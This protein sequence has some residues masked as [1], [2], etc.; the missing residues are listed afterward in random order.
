MADFWAEDV[1]NDDGGRVQI[2]WA[3][4]VADDC[5]FVTVYMMPV[6]D[7]ENVPTNVDDMTEVAIVPDCE[8]N[9]TIIDSIGENSLVDG[10]AY[11]IGAVA[12]D[13]WLNGDTGDVTV[14]EV[15]PFVNNLNG[16]SEPERISEL[17]AYDHPDDDGTAIDIS[18]APSQVDDFDFYVVWVSEYPLNDLTET[19]DRAGTEPGICGCIVMDKQWIDTEK[20]PIELTLNTALYGGNNLATS[21]PQLIMPDVQLY[22]AITVH[23]VK[24]NVHLDNLNTAT[25]TPID[26][27][28]DTTPP[29]RLSGL[30]LYDRA[31]DDGTAVMLEF[32][33]SQDSDVAY[34][35]V[36]AAAFTFTSVGQ[37]GTVK[38][39]VATLDRT[40][41]L[42]LTIDI[43][44]F[45]T[46]VVPNTPVTVAVVPVDWSGNAY[47]DN[48]VTSTAI[49]INDG[50][51]DVGAYLPD[52][53][54]VSLEWLD[55]SILVSWEHTT[56]P[57]VR[58]YVVYISDSEFENV[59][60]ATNVGDASVSN[61]FLIT[62]EIFP[63]LSNDSSWW[64]GVS[65]K[66]DVNNRKVIQSLRIGP[67]DS[68]D[69][70]DKG[71]DGKDSTTDLGELLTTDNLIIA[72]MVLI[73]LLLLL[74]VI[75]GREGSLQE[76]RN[77]NCKKP[78]GAFNR[79]LAGT[80]LVRSVDRLHRLLH[81]RPPS[82]QLNKMTSML[83]L[84][85][86]SSQVSLLCHSAG[87]NKHNLLSNKNHK[88]Q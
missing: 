66:D 36:Y 27:L 68:T 34:Y 63:E 24:G 14:L 4:S 55:D 54:G 71:D 59:A 51:E 46:L 50:I 15:T 13:K 19:W 42:P 62:P 83:L 33:L 11:W 31:G 44:V 48:L 87:N 40:P 45:D 56:D 81:L 2:G 65:A 3:N 52:I 20:S 25:A 23:D 7:G 22:V 69:N 37:S 64:V 18:W 75:R 79:S 12:F 67:I 84:K 35:E 16:P 17:S 6:Q 74:L 26:N 58:R 73:S 32:E 80:M 38:S 39:P 53:N 47:R 9:M 82:S 43:L 49:A 77:G 86:Y 30:N 28:A 85:E 10:Q 57:N 29:E 76:T 8:T 60:D 1:P 70:S 88:V 41:T 5:A 21:I 61:T 72:G 78:L